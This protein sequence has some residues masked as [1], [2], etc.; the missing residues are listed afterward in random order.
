MA[1]RKLTVPEHHQLKIALATL[2]M[3]EAM[4]NV[5]GGPNHQEAIEIIK[6][7]TGRTVRP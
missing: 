6:R 7:L 1:D 4:A 3:P 5:M 2:R